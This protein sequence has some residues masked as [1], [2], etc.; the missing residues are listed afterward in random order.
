MNAH[1]RQELGDFLRRRRAELT[2]EDV[3][4]PRQGRRRATGL[5]REEVAQLAAISLTWYTWI[6]QGREVNFSVEVLTSIA[7]AL[8]LQPHE[9][10]YIFTLCGL[11]P[12]DQP[13]RESLDPL[14]L[15]LV[16]HQGLYPAYIMGRYWQLLYLNEAA[17][18]LFTGFND[19]PPERRNVLWYVFCTD[20]PR[21]VMRD[22]ES[23]ARRLV[24][25]FRAEYNA[26]LHERWVTQLI[27]DVRQ[28]N[29]HF[30]TWWDEHQVSYKDDVQ[31]VFVHPL[32]GTV[33]FTQYTLRVMGATDVR[34]VVEVPD[35]LT[36]TAAKLQA[37]FEAVRE[38]MR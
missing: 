4:M 12:L 28:I 33:S 8:A 31:K 2:P 32:L 38:P 5:K 30:N 23:H 25:E 16:E 7:R 9:E 35:P 3:G 22:W 27:D 13:R 21:Q 34:L 24:A 19:L 37:H 10:R 26:Y 18:V 1:E 15:D 11:T 29:P 36:D 6:E 14:L 17:Q 20:R